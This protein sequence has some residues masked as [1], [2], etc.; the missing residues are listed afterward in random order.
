[1]LYV[2][3]GVGDTFVKAKKGKKCDS[4]DFHMFS[5]RL[6]IYKNV[7]VLLTRHVSPF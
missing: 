4:N 1:M 6:S 7:L 5:A 2:E 3:F